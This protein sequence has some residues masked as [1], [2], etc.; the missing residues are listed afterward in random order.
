MAGTDR[1]DGGHV[2]RSRRGNEFRLYAS[3]LRNMIRAVTLALLLA[4]NLAGLF[5]RPLDIVFLLDVGD[6]MIRP[7]EFVVAGARLATYEF[8]ND[9]QVA[10]LSYSSGVKVRSGFT[11]DAS[12]IE[13]AFHSCIRTR[14]THGGQSGLYDALLMAIGHFSESAD[15]SRDRVIAV[16]TNNN[17]MSSSDVAREVILKARAK[18]I[19]VSFFLVASPFSSSGSAKWNVPRAPYP[20]VHVAA[21]K[22]APLASETGGNVFIKDPNGYVLR[23]IIEACRRD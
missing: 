23:Q 13:R 21:R 15:P 11:N 14:I 3:N 18:G 1:F 20:D 7:A 19:V 5:A 22:L 17:G 4:S 8:Q 16:I 10:V 2:S 9:D 12:H 6:T